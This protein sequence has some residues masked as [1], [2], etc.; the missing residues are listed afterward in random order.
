MAKRSPEARLLEIVG[1]LSDVPFQYDDQKQALKRITELGKEAMNSHTCTLAFV[2]LDR[3]KL[4]HAAW[5]SSHPEMEKFFSEHDELPIEGYLD[6]NVVRAGKVLELYDLQKDGQGVVNPEIAKK[7]GINSLLGHPLHS[8]SSLIGYINHFSSER[9]FTPSQK[10]LIEIFAHQAMLTIDKFDQYHT[11]NRSSSIL[12]EL[13]K[14]L[15][16]D[17]PAD[18]LQAVAEKARDLLL[19]PICIIW[20]QVDNKLKIVA[21]TDEVDDDYRQLELDRNNDD[22]KKHLS[23][24]EVSYIPEVSKAHPRQT[25]L[26]EI[27]RRGW[28]SLM[29]VPLQVNDDLIGMLEVFTKHVRHFKEWEKAI[30]A[31][32]ANHAA[33]SFQKIG[34]L[35]ETEDK[36]KLEKLAEIILEMSESDDVDSLLEIFL[37]GGL[38]LVGGTRGLVRQLDY[39]TDDLRAVASS[40]EQPKYLIKYP[41]GITGKA[42]ADGRPVRA[43]NIHSPEWK[44][45]YVEYWEDTKSEMAIPILLNKARIREGKDV[46]Q[47][48]K[49]I[50]VLNIESPKPKAFSRTDEGCLWSLA[51][52]AAL[53]IDRIESD[54]KLND[55]RMVEDRIVKETRQDQIMS[56]L[57]RGIKRILGFDYV[58]ILRVIPDRKCIQAEYVTGIEEHE[59]NLFKQQAVYPLFVHPLEGDNYIYANIVRHEEIEVPD[60]DDNRLDKKLAKRFRIDDLARVF[61]PLIDPATKRVTGVVEAGYKKKY[62]NHIYERDVE[63]L[64]RLVDYAAQALQLEKVYLMDQIIHELSTPIVGLR[65]NASFLERRF[66]QLSEQ[67]M[68]NKLA[69][70]LIDSTILSYQVEE[71]E[72]F[73]GKPRRAPKLEETFVYRDVIIKT[74][75]QL[76]PFIAGR[77]LSP[78]KVIYNPAGSQRIRV[79]TDPSRLNQVVFNLLINSV[80]YAEDN[81]ND[82][83][84]QIEV[85]ENRDNFIIKFQDWG[86]GIDEPY[87]SRVFERGFRTPQAKR[88]DVYSSGLGLTISRAIMKELGGD[89]RLTNNRKPTEFQMIIPKKREGEL[90]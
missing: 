69:D 64:K 43:G 46:K 7:Y 32:F 50:G 33:L 74:I 52:Y 44:G 11:F 15:L 1:A 70:M 16:R 85:K 82:F 38:D 10:R 23:S 29:T 56:T 61:V 62:R 63:M 87:V 18:F 77:G 34:L 37:K 54:K 57:L 88:K 26:N 83:G 53:M 8:N 21:A 73:F 86:I 78:A 12:K 31:T 66:S 4:T 2:D 58:N 48:V 25:H 72:Y 39:A 51:R 13:S 9:K 28:V 24:N 5:A 76:R 49:P 3:R 20:K 84:V 67:L 55:L 81:P 45:I 68:S 47:G 80:K 30:F 59:I 60:L 79:F 90:Q 17:N 40:G 41:T 71:L 6:F 89:L 22:V 75:N 42:L 27:E 35:K 36:R 19:V 65:S 14:S